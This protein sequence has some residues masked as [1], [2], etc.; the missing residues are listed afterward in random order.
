[1]K[2]IFP[3]ADCVQDGPQRSNETSSKGSSALS[4][5]LSNGQRVCCPRTQSSHFP[6]R[7]FSDMFKPSTSLFLA[8]SWIVVGLQW[9]NRRCHCSREVGWDKDDI[10]MGL[11]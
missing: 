10:A 11:T 1:M 9:A 2:K 6:Q 7:D 3:P 8:I 5:S 4:V